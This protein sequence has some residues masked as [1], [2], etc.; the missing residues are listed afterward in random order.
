MMA[1]GM[2][3]SVEKLKDCEWEDEN[4]N[5]ENLVEKLKVTENQTI[6]SLWK[7][8]FSKNKNEKFLWD[9]IL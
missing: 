7:K 3:R 1:I 9:N 6:L 2:S 8:S 4:K 5:V